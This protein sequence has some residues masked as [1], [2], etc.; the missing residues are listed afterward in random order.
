MKYRYL[1]KVCK[2]G[3][4]RLIETIKP[5]PLA[6]QKLLGLE[7]VPRK[8]EEFEHDGIMITDRTKSPC[9]RFDLNDEESDKLYGNA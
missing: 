8:R 3:K 7:N 6:A 5:I 9:G 4:R 2:D 1:T